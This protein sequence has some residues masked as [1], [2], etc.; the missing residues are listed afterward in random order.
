MYSGIINQQAAE[1]IDLKK[2]VYLVFT[3]NKQAIT[4]SRRM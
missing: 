2:N 1:P 3:A 4:L